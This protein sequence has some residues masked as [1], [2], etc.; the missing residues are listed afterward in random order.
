MTFADLLTQPHTL[1]ALRDLWIVIDAATA[2]DLAAKQDAFGSTVNRIA[3]VAGPA[4]DPR[5][6]LCADLVTEIQPG[7]MHAHLFSHLNQSA[8]ASVVVA[9]RADLEAAGWFAPVAP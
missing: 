4:S 5:Y 8:F 7:G 9:P 3:P 1:A 2:A 6:A